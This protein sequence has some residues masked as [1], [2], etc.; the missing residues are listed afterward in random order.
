MSGTEYLP[1]YSWL[2][3]SRTV[4]LLKGHDIKLPSIYFSVNLEI[5]Q[6]SGFM[7]EAF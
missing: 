4:I 1:T 7:K 3:N 5:N 6:F 2:G